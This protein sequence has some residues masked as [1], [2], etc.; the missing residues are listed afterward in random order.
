MWWRWSRQMWRECGRQSYMKRI[1]YSFCWNISGIIL[2]SWEFFTPV[3][4][5][6]FS[7]KSVRPQVSKAFFSRPLETIPVA[8]TVIDITI[9][10]MFYSFFSS[11]LR[12]KYLSIFSLSF[13]LTLW[14]AG[15]AK[16]TKRQ[17][18]SFLSIL[19]FVFWQGLGD[20]FV[21]QSPWEF[22]P[23]HFRE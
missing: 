18:L 19:G 15:M 6:G 1:R 4:T 12:S 21:S 2:I 14:S 17:V 16:S 8:P 10:S 20:P 7:L 9:T 22:C 11:L 23:S 5:V 13:I 3:L